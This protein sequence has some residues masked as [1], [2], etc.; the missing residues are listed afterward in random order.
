MKSNNFYGPP[1][2]LGKITPLSLSIVDLYDIVAIP[3]TETP[4]RLWKLLFTTF[5]T[6]STVQKSLRNDERPPLLTNYDKSMLINCDKFIV[7]LLNSPTEKYSW[8]LTFH[9]HRC[10]VCYFYFIFLVNEFFKVTLS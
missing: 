4:C 7:L 1:L 9:V 6:R 10:A 8:I 3:A 2:D 5:D